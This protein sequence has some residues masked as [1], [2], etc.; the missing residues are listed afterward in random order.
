MN[1]VGTGAGRYHRRATPR[2][3]SAGATGSPGGPTATRRRLDAELVRRGLAG[4]REQARA[5]VGSGGVLVAGAPAAKPDRLVQPGEALVVTAGPPPFVSRGGEKLAAALDAFAIDVGGLRCLDAG[6]STGGFSDCLLQRGAASVWAVDVG[7]GQLHP[8][9]RQDPRVTVRERTNVRTLTPAATAGP[10]PV[11]VADLS[12]I[13]LASVA[14]ALVGLTTAEPPGRLL[15][16]VK[17]QFEAG[18]AE[19]SRGRGVI[20]DPVVHRRVL[21]EVVDAWAAAG[22]VATGVVRSPVRGGDGNVEFFLHL[23]PAPAAASGPGSAPGTT[24]TTALAAALDAAVDGGGD[25]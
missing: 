13:S 16:L 2:C 20:R 24:P 14:P 5:L 8:R 22:A 25:G 6:A 4:S 18:R 11:V 17:P 12:F 7:H 3:R 10:F 21:G 19:A 15:V 1:E 23:R 9:V